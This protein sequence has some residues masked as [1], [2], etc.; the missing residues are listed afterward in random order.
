MYRSTLYQEDR[1]ISDVTSWCRRFAVVTFLVAA[2]VA[3]G[4]GYPAAQSL[5]TL[6]PADTAR[7]ETLVPSPT[8]LGLSPD[9]SVLA[10]RIDRSNWEDELRITRRTD[11]RALVVPYGRDPEY[12]A[13]GRW[14][15]YAIG[16]SRDAEAQLERDRRPVRDGLG[17][18]QLSD[19]AETR[20][21]DV[22]SAAFSADGAYVAIER[23]AA[24]PT[25]GRAGGGR[26]GSA[27]DSTRVYVRPLV[28]AGGSESAF[29]NVQQFDWQPEQ[30][31]RLAMLMGGDN[32]GAARVQIVDPSVP[33][34]SATTV[35]DDAPASFS[36][37]TWRGNGADLAYLRSRSHT[38]GNG[39]TFDVVAV[40]GAGTGARALTIYDAARDPSFP[41]GARVVDTRAVS[42]SQDGRTLFVGIADAAPPAG[43]A[44]DAD[45]SDADVRIWH[46]TD[47]EVMP[48]Q[49]ENA[50]AAPLKNRPAAVHIDAGRLVPLTTSL[51]SRAAP[52]DGTALAWVADWT[53]YA[54]A[55][56]IGRPAAD[57]ALV[58]TRTGLHTPFAANVDDNEVRVRPDGGALVFLRDDHLWSLNTATRA[59]TD[60]SAASGAA[61][62][63]LASDST[64]THKPLFG[65]GGW[66]TEGDLIA[67]DR[68]DIWRIAADGATS[69]RLTDGAATRTRHRLARFDEADAAR[70]IDLTRPVYIALFGERTKQSGY[71]RLTPAVTTTGRLERLI[72]QDRHLDRLT[73]SADGRVYAYIAMDFDASPNILVGSAALT[74]ATAATA[75]NPQQSRYAWGRS[76]VIDYTTS[77]G[78]A[79]QAALYYPAGYV[80]GRRYPTIVTLYERLSDEVHEYVAPSDMDESNIAIFTQLGYA[81]I[82]PD[83]RYQPR[84]P[85]ASTVD[86]VTAAVA[87]AVALGVT[88]GAHVGVIGHSWGAYGS[89]FLATHTTGIFAAAVAGSPITDLISQYGNHHWSSGLAE[90]DHIETGQQR[91]QV[92]FYDDVDAYVRNSP[93]FG[94][95]KMTTP[96]LLEAGDQDGE[97]FWHQSVELYN[98][99]RRAGKPVVLLQYPDED[100]ALDNFDNRRDYQQRILAWFGHYLKNETAPRWITTGTP[101]AKRSGT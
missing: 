9:G 27:P 5:P 40:R 35:I 34:A 64:A 53:A 88:D 36:R 20:F 38:N 75:T 29:D 19:F 62:I 41:A 46:W 92:P 72:Y 97:V 73:T 47:V 8:R 49:V 68:Y 95:P 22:E 51:T 25:A 26:R 58:D 63:D 69:R 11:G 61:L 66:T 31:H 33:A 84:D 54:M 98:A 94:V 37:L 15:M 93:I 89:A 44:R 6:R 30:G 74:D 87:R 99:A 85:G 21:A 81:V 14:L 76:A 79:L 71:A 67:Y 60:L 17:L 23:Y 52:I 65:I 2:S 39:L 101:F 18:L 83:I 28:S 12:S 45:A 10:Y 42:W 90:T 77:R 48:H 4:A 3:A 100:H 43:D 78:D 50:D 91:M 80:A 56:T 1:Y 13:D 24:R 96:L 57:L 86:C 70:A 32:Q 59:L 82:A 55:R 7:W 16:R